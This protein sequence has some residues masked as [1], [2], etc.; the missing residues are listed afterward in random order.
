MKVE[1]IKDIELFAGIGEED[2]LAIL[3]VCRPT[4]FRRNEVI[5]EIDSEGSELFILVRGRVAIEVAP[6]TGDTMSF[7][8]ER[9]LFGELAL[10][11]GHRRSAKVTALDDVE[12]LSLRREDLEILLAGNPALGLTLMKNLTRIIAAKLRDT[13]M[14]MRN[15]LRQQQS[16]LQ[17]L[18]LL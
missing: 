12:L 10:V 17:G 11:D 16:L 14:A 18:N 8:P 9:R 15:L 13:N 5:F 2:L 4:Q 1:G 7:V 3:T 6:G